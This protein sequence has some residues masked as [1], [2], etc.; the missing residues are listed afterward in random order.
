M[1]IRD[2]SDGVQQ[3]GQRHHAPPSGHLRVQAL[4]VKQMP[5]QWGTGPMRAPMLELY[6]R[7]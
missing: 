1:P 3:W 7:H 2:D 5:K 4:E 6:D